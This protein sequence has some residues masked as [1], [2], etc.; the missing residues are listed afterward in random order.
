MVNQSIASSDKYVT[1]SGGGVLAYVPGCT[2]VCNLYRSANIVSVCCVVTR[3]SPNTK[4]PQ[5]GVPHLLDH[6][7][8]LY[9]MLLQPMMDSNHSDSC[10][11][12]SFLENQ[13]TGNEDPSMAAMNISEDIKVKR[14]VFVDAIYDYTKNRHVLI[15]LLPVDCTNESG[16]G[17]GVAPNVETRCEWVR[18]QHL[19]LDLRGLRM[20]GPTRQFTAITRRVFASLDRWL[21]KVHCDPKRVVSL[22]QPR[23][24]NRLKICVQNQNCTAVQLKSSPLRTASRSVI[25][26]LF[27]STLILPTSNQRQLFSKQQNVPETFGNVFSTEVYRV[28]Q[29]YTV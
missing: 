19:L 10:E 18:L 26:P 16:D 8:R 9:D 24:T 6:Y 20:H 2:R 4:W 14:S 27:Q 17:T 12:Y 28:S 1:F 22:W 25:N 3:R 5:G 23:A 7:G 29:K 13:V 21:F 15:F 11:K